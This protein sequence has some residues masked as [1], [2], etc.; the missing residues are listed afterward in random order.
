MKKRTA[1]SML[2]VM[3][4]FALAACSS[5][6]NGSS[7]NANTPATDAASQNANAAGADESA[8]SGDEIAP[9]P[10]ASL[11]IWVDRTERAFIDEV[12]PEFTEKYGVQVTIE[13]VNIPQQGERLETDGPANLAADVLMLPHDKLSKLVQANLIYPNDLF[14]EETKASSLETAIAASSIDGVLYGYPQSIETFALFYNKALV[15]EVP[16]TWDDVLAFAEGY[17]D[18]ASK[19]Y[20]IAWLHNLYFN[21]MF[22]FPYGGYVFGDDG[23]DA[24]DIGLNSPESVEGLKYYQS[25]KQAAPINTTDLTYDIQLEL[26]TSGKLAMTID[27]PWSINAYQGKVD[28]GIAPLPDLPGGKKTISMAGVRSFY[29]NSYTPYPTAAKL[30]A[31]YLVSTENALKNF[32]LA[33]ILPANKNAADDPRIKNDPILSGIVEQF[34]HSTTM[35][36]IAEMNLVWAPTDA[37]FAAIWNN[38]ADVQATMDTA[39]QSIKDLINS[40]TSQ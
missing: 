7:S 19:K 3:I 2:I 35:P 10:G 18:A 31:S 28:F 37:A 36:S 24:A 20:A 14:E 33:N 16:A 23:T 34:N 26:F 17:N 5:G 12:I 38:N 39:V 22:M 21:S 9:E 29:V 13:E 11:K 32:E 4:V 40:A 27:G 6:N 8:A 30:L 25:L 1:L 15:N